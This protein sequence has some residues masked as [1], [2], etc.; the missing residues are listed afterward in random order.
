MVI[1]T[2]DVHAPTHLNWS[3]PTVAQRLPLELKRTDE[4]LMTKAAQEIKRAH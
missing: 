2:E 3:N 4:N 1:V